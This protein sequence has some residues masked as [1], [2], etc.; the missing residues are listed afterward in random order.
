MT[1]ITLAI[2]RCIFLIPTPMTDSSWID[3]ELTMN[4]GEH[5]FDIKHSF[6]DPVLWTLL[7]SLC[8]IWVIRTSPP[9]SNDSL[10]G[11]GQLKIL[12]SLVFCG[13][14]AWLLYFANISVIFAHLLKIGVYVDGTIMFVAIACLV[15]WII[16]SSFH[17]L[18]HMISS[19]D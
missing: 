5:A 3:V 12:A 6:V 15:G 11:A 4:G 10:S 13:I 19:R 18:R 16:W 9:I 8:A 17:G 14:L 2:S 1:V 7:I